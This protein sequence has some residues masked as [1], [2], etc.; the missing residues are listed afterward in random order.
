MEGIVTLAEYA[1]KFGLPPPTEPEEPRSARSG[2]PR[3]PDGTP[4]KGEDA[5]LG[6]L[7]AE[8]EAEEGFTSR[9]LKKE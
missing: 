1:R 4:M 7:I 5:D 6:D 9:P 8:I 3:N 2:T